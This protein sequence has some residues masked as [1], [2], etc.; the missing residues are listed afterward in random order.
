MQSLTYIDNNIQLGIAYDWDMI[1]KSYKALNCPDDVYNP[2]PALRS[3]VENNTNKL[4][5]ITS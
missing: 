5:C 4:F 3:M 1:F 2:V